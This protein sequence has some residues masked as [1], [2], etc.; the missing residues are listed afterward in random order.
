MVGISLAITPPYEL[1][2]TPIH[3]NFKQEDNPFAGRKT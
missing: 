2:G 1:K 3:L